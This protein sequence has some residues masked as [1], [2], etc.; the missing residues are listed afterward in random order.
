MRF[1]T[2]RELVNALMDR[3]GVREFDLEIQVFGVDSVNLTAIQTETGLG[4][5]VYTGLDRRVY[6]Q[7]LL[8]RLANYA[9]GV[10]RVQIS[11]PH[12]TTAGKIADEIVDRF[13]PKATSVWAKSSMVYIERSK[14]RSHLEHFVLPA[15]FQ[16]DMQ[17]GFFGSDQSWRVSG[18]ARQHSVEMYIS[19][20][21][22]KAAKILNIIREE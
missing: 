17:G 11:L 16:S 1:D 9:D 5:L 8:G 20:D 14:A 15:G 6:V 10:R 12:N 7:Q 22:D 2:A 19:A 4:F 18:K 21:P 13:L 3:R